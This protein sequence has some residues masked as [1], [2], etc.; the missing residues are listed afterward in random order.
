MVLEDEVIGMERIDCKEEMGQ[1]EG[2]FHH[3]CLIK[4]HAAARLTTKKKGLSR[5]FRQVI[6]DSACVAALTSPFMYNSLVECQTG[7]GDPGRA[8]LHRYLV[9][10]ENRCLSEHTQDVKHGRA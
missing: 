10:P 3:V 5:V 8:P 9:R 6:C 1:K 4:R 2:R 7:R